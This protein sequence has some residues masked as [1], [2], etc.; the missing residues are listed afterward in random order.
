MTLITKEEDS[1]D[2]EEATASLAPAE[3]V[4]VDV[5]VAAVLSELDDIFTFNEEQRSALKAFLGLTA[6]FRFTPNRLWQKFSRTHCSSP[7]GD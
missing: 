7:R 2:I 6:Y 4:S 5:A 1:K 3:D